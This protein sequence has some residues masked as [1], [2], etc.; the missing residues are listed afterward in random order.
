MKKTLNEV[1]DGWK[2]G[3]GIFA[4]LQNCDVPWKYENIS[5]K[6]DILYHGSHSGEK[7]IAPLIKAFLDQ[8]GV[9]H[10]TDAQTIAN[11]IFTECGL[12]W[13][14]LWDTQFF[15]YDPISNYDMTEHEEATGEVGSSTDANNNIFG[16]NTTSTTGVPSDN[17]HSES[18]GSSGSERDLTRKGNI[19]V[20]TSQQMIESERELWNYFFYDRVFKDIDRFLTLSI[21]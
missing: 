14:K 4:F 19:G 1:F 6:L 13:G 10:G 17:S 8:D 7:T 3:H 2:S 18:S 15:D 5:D 20:T 9:L 11:A 12:N 21:Y 16:F